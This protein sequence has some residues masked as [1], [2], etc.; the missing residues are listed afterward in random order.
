MLRTFSVRL[1]S[2]NIVSYQTT[3]RIQS[4]IFLMEW[5]CWCAGSKRQISNGFPETAMA[6]G[7]VRCEWHSWLMVL[8][9][10]SLRSVCS[11]KLLF[12]SF[13]GGYKSAISYSTAFI[14]K[15][16]PR[17]QHEVS[18][19]S[20]NKR[21]FGPKQFV[22]ADNPSLRV[23]FARL[24]WRAVKVATCEHKDSNPEHSKNPNLKSE[25]YFKILPVQFWAAESLRACKR[26]SCM[27]RFSLGRCIK[28][29]TSHHAATSSA[30]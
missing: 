19:Y 11:Q 26:F 20:Q 8:W 16:V 27:S 29:S 4:K 30:R 7:A 10:P 9:P 18:T 21:R 3:F 23:F 5:F 25:E 28:L 15:A 6:F 22:P 1:P 12:D 2:K 17:G 13:L 24:L 14:T